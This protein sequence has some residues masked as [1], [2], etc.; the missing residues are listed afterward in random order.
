MKFDDENKDKLEMFMRS[1]ENSALTV[2]KFV[3]SN[4]NLNKKQSSIKTFEE[5]LNRLSTN[6]TQEYLTEALL[7]AERALKH[8]QDS[9]KLQA[10][11]A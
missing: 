8:Q 5:L 2:K 11:V 6:R 7:N 9:E 3:E 4:Q 1:S 10:V